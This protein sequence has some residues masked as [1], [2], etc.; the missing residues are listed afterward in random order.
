MGVVKFFGVDTDDKL[1]VLKQTGFDAKQVASLNTVLESSTLYALGLDNSLH[2][3]K[4]NPKIRLWTRNVVQN[5]NT[6]IPFRM[7]RYRTQLTC[8]DGN[9]Y[10]DF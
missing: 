3:L 6:K 8:R 10:R 2:M 7:T 9:D 4:Q 5:P 1:R